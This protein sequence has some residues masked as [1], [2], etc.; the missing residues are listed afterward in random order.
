MHYIITLGL[1]ISE[2]EDL[3]HHLEKLEEMGYSVTVEDETDES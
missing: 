3:G 1:E 2:F